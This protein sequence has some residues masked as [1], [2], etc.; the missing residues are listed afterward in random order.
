MEGYWLARDGRWRAV[1]QEPPHRPGEVLETAAQPPGD[2]GL[3][4]V[5][6]LERR[7]F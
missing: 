6:E 2:N 5:D 3:R 7:L 4:E 1:A